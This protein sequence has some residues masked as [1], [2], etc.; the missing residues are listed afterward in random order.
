VCHAVGNAPEQPTCSREATAPD[1]DDLG[2]RLLRDGEQRVGGVARPGVSL[3]LDTADVDPH[4][5]LVEDTVRLV[6]G[7]LGRACVR[8]EPGGSNERR[9]RTE[10]R[11][12]RDDVDACPGQ[13]SE[14]DGTLDGKP[15]GLR[16]VGADDDRG[17]HTVIVR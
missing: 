10:R 16:A 7:D 13:P 12:R 14:L 3:D 15:S 4:Q 11:V 9:A 17:E 6:C 8:D 2:A 1:D 5:C